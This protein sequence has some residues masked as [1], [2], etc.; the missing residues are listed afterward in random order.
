MNVRHVHNDFAYGACFY[1]EDVD[2]V[3]LEYSSFIGSYS[4]QRG[5]VGHITSLNKNGSVVRS[6]VFWNNSA[7]SYGGNIYVEHEEAYMIVITFIN[8]SCVNGSSQIT[9]GHWFGGNISAVVIDCAFRNC[10]ANETLTSQAFGGA[11]HIIGGA[12]GTIV[13]SSFVN[14][15]SLKFVF[16]YFFFSLSFSHSLSL[17]LSYSLSL[18]LLF[19]IFIFYFYFYFHFYF[20]FFC[21]ILLL[22][23]FFFTRSGGAIGVGPLGS[24]AV[25]RGCVFY[26]NSA[27]S[28]QG[29]DIYT[30]GTLTVSIYLFLSLI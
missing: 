4:D 3:D 27:G 9:G 20:F 1:L 21:K 19:F 12:A 14:C 28:S 11:L 17:S 29:H 6:C 30:R 26:N 15:Y 2:D 13:N 22:Y 16:L 24:T 25:I 23:L 18:I 7:D 8:C 5:G 10:Q